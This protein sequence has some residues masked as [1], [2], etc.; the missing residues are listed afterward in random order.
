MRIIK[1]LPVIFLTLVLLLSACASSSSAKEIR[2]DM[3]RE[4][5]FQVPQTDESALVNGNNSFAFDL[6]GSLR[7]HE[8]NLVFSPYSIS[9]AIAMT[10]AGSKGETESQMEKVMH[11]NLPQ[12]RLH[13]A[14]N[15][16]DQFLTKPGLPASKDGQPFQLNIANSLWVEKTLS[17][18]KQFLDLIS[19]NYGAAIHLADFISQPE[20]AQKEINQWASDQ[21]HKK[22]VEL[23]P[24]GAL[25]PMTR[26]VLANAIY[27]KAD[28][29]DQF[30]PNDT[31]DAP[32]YF[33]DGSVSNVK[34]MS[35]NFSNIPYLIENGFQ[36]L[37][38]NYLGDSADMVLLV[39][40]LGKFDE[41]EGQFNQEK[42]DEIISRLQPATLSL[43]MPKFSFETG[44]DLSQQLSN[45]GM[46]DSFE[47][48]HADFSG[49]TGGRDLFI[50]RVLH[51][52]FVDVDE[53][54]T[55]AAAATTVIMSTTSIMLPEVNLVIDRPF[56]F[57]IRDKLSQQILFLGR[58]L[59]PSK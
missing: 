58:V 4:L 7:G 38:I 29:A 9:L 24:K 25:D 21:T 35:N 20:S 37:E 11:F 28:W 1:R 31:K 8:G 53:K 30:D 18:E 5:N 32:F 45:L 40:D 44:V 46:S 56:I 34:M 36:A 16:L 54:G 19:I 59:I 43:G 23:I 39:P 41:F 26:L 2:S 55:E 6:Y 10:Y 42:F 3:P 33:V 52:A 47:S 14:F 17:I 15:Q 50:S 27:F 13:P 49:M 12:D 48:D 57:I 51:R 22:I